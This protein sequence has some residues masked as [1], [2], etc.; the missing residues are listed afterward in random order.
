MAPKKSVVVLWRG[1]FCRLRHQTDFKSLRIETIRRLRR[2][3]SF[4]WRLY[5]DNP[6]TTAS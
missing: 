2:A 6:P 4:S 3:I 5:P 1:F